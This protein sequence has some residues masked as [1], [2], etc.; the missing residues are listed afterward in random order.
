MCPETQS[1]NPN[2]LVHDS[3]V[4][5]KTDSPPGPCCSMGPVLW[6][7]FCSLP[8]AVSSDNPLNSTVGKNRQLWTIQ[9]FLCRNLKDYGKANQAWGKELT[10]SCRQ[11][12]ITMGVLWKG[13]T[14]SPLCCNFSLATLFEFPHRRPDICA[15][16][17]S[18]RLR[19]G[20]RGSSMTIQEEES[21]IKTHSIWELLWH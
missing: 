19:S 9:W 4:L 14:L 12:P 10:S 11:G 2:Q 20:G 5:G 6:D 13:A 8:H 21:S 18:N 1:L 17:L 7:L 3:F 16:F 15:L